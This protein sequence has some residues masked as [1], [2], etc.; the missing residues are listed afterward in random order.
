MPLLRGLIAGGRERRSASSLPPLYGRQ[1]AAEVVVSPERA[2]QI[3]AVY[4]CVRL[5]AETGSMLP[6]DVVERRGSARYVVDD[7]PA[8]QLLT[9]EPNP[10]MHAGEF[11][12]LMLAWQLLRGNALAFIE[13]N[14]AGAPV[15]LWPI[16]WTSV[17]D[18]RRASDGQLVYQ[19]MLDTDEY[20]PIGGPSAL[21]RA[22]QVLHFRAFGVDGIRGLSPIGM[23]RQAVGLGHAA[24]SYI[25]RF[26]ARDASPGAVLSVPGKL[27]TEQYERLEQQWLAAHEGFERSH[28]LRILEGGAS[29]QKVSLAPADAAFMDIYKMT[30]ADIAGVYG[31]PPHMIGDVDRSTSW[32]AGI[33]QQSLGY[34]LYSLTPWLTRLERT[35]RRVL[36]GPGRRVKFR[37]NALTRGD[38]PARTAYYSA[39]RNGG[40]MSANDIR[41]LEDEE[42]IAGGDTYLQPLNMVPAGTVPVPPQRSA[43]TARSA[44]AVPD[45]SAMV[46]LYPPAQLADQ[47][48]VPGGLP[49]EQLHVTLAYLGAE[50]TEQQRADAA[51]VV[52]SVARQH[53]GLAGGIGGLGQFAA[54]DDG[55]PVYAPVDVPGLA[56]LRHRLV[57]QLSAAGVPVAVDHGY[58]PHLTLTYLADGDTPP[59]PVEPVDVAFGALSL[60]VGADRTDYGFTGTRARS[61]PPAPH[62]RA[63]SAGAGQP[64]PAAYPAWVARHAEKLGAHFARQHAD[65]LAR[66]ADFGAD[67]TAAQLLDAAAEDEALATVLAELAEDFAAEV[68]SSVAA[69]LGGGYRVADAARW[70]AINAEAEAGNINATVLAELAEALGAT[71]VQQAVRDMFGTLTEARAQQ[72]A[73][74]RVSLIGNFAAQDAAT[75]SGVH[76]KTWRITSDDPR[77]SHLAA[78]GQTVPIDQTFEVGGHRGRW[79]HDYTLGVDEIAGCTCILEFRA[80]D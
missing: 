35:A 1:T 73:R 68:G 20:A 3:G 57:E 29:W 58:T 34:V 49:A 76:N 26:F 39:S 32:G 62:S 80:G 21:L 8:G 51:A 45:G 2:L 59:A 67:V 48:A 44:G 65:V 55:I 27:D 79:P 5:L 74:A 38:L 52:A 77:A 33:E 13:R 19:V 15:G 60:T 31:V 22:D 28:K 53:T 43:R 9:N 78:N 75:Q 6:V 17:A 16:S 36:A 64:L 69:A 50:L 47:L 12:S 18:L 70:I 46:A 72:L 7:D 30:R 40:W 63:V 24:L 66:I 41:A 42:P 54:G 14:G 4:S 25:G 71:D 23:N 61:A 56:E 10:N 11:W 37:T